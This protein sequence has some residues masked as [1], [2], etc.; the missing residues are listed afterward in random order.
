[1][2]DER[3]CIMAQIKYQNSM[4]YIWKKMDQAS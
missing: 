4:G 2:Q 3:G 1:M